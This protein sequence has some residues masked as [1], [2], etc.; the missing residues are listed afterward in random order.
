MLSLAVEIKGV[1]VVRDLL[2]KG[3]DIAIVGDNDFYSP[4]RRFVENIRV[5]QNPFNILFLAGIVGPS[6]NSGFPLSNS[7]L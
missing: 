5:A 6:Q 4:R 1:Q 3:I 2:S 7:P